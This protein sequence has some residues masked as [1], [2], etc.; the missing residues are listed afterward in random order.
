MLSRVS[1]RKLMVILFQ[2][3]IFQLENRRNPT[4]VSP[5]LGCDFTLKYKL[6]VTGESS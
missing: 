6:S 1:A 4:E 2:L 5:E 3:I